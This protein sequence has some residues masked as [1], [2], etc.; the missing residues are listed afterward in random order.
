MGAA[1]KY[2]EKRVR[3]Q[4][5]ALSTLDSSSSAVLSTAEGQYGVF[6]LL[7]FLFLSESL[8]KDTLELAMRP[9]CLTDRQA[10]RV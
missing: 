4:E 10:K 3:E 7:L 2:L 6:P 8:C 5:A 1:K 9:V